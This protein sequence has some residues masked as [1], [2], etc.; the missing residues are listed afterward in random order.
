MGL[1][2][3]GV[4][5]KEF[6]ANRERF[7]ENWKTAVRFPSVGAD[8]AHA[9]DCRACAGWFSARL[10]EAGF[11]TEL[12]ETGAPPVVFG[13]RRGKPGTPVILLY[14]HYDVQPADPLEAWTS[15]PFDPVFRDGRLYGRGAQDNK[16]QLVYVL[17]A[18]ET[19]NRLAGA[20]LC[21]IKV[22]LEGQEE[23]G[24]DGLSHAL[25][26]WAERL[27]ADVLMVTDTFMAESGAPSIVMGLRGIVHLTVTVEGPLRDLH[28]GCHGG[29][30]PN[31]ADALCRLIAG[32]HRKDGRL[33]VKG[34]DAGCRPA[35]AREKELLA[36]EPFDSARYEAQTG[37]PPA[38]GE[39]AIAPYERLGFRPTI[40]VNGI[41]GGY[42]GAGSKTIIPARA[43]AK[44][45][46]RLTAGQDPA[47]ALAAIEAHLKK[48]APAGL[49]VTVSEATVGGPALC[50]DA[51]A[52][53][54]ARAA[55][56][57]R[58]VCGREAAYHWE[59]AS[60]PVLTLLA[61]VAG[62]AQPLLIGFGREEDQ[63]HAPNES[64][65]QERFRLGYLFMTRFLSGFLT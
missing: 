30:A 20:D 32:L 29:L 28:S 21:T 45:S 15:P 24:S 16:G 9:E 19:L 33:A 35:T 54:A 6:D 12:L 2:E 51:D 10:R 25:P 37:V 13:V 42:G 38:G 44:L 52:P 41:H 36:R 8:P 27:K 14:G 23:S 46:A 65:A 39:T 53:L 26:G 22:L 56:V 64:F 18:L 50:L 48:H 49:R 40:E 17:A 7:F 57:L 11:D 47:K 62:G 61:R 55:G 58:E 3:L 4:A 60:I 5:A 1:I 63:V 34:F 31:P 43:F 59:G